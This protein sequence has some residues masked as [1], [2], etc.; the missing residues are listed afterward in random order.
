MKL[1][2][3]NGIDVN[4]ASST[5]GWNALVFLSRNNKQHDA[6]IPAARLLVKAGI[7]IKKKENDNWNLLHFLRNSPIRKNLTQSIRYLV[8]ETDIDRKVVT[9]GARDPSITCT[10]WQ[11]KRA[12]RIRIWTKLS[13]FLRD[14]QTSIVFLLFQSTYFTN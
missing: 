5:Q 9:N 7:D 2:V 13:L 8:K 1:L 12:T 3:K 10:S 11:V 4:A 14:K 6:F